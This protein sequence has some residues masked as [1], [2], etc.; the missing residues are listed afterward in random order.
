M[1]FSSTEKG[2]FKAVGTTETEVEKHKDL[3]RQICTPLGGA[4]AV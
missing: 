2:M 1:E 3:F 4:R